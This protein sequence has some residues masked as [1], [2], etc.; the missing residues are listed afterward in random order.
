MIAAKFRAREAPPISCFTLRARAESRI[1]V[2]S[3]L[4]QVHSEEMPVFSFEAQ[5]CIRGYHIYKAVWAPYIGE[6]MPCSRE[7]TNGHDPFAVKVS[8]LHGEERIV[9][10]LPKKISSI[11]SIFLRR[12]KRHTH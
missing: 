12:G 4:S 3:A 11:C 6:T 10:H 5:S 8:Q 2:T 1:F 9:G 7:L